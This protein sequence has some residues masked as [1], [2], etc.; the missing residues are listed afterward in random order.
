MSD[1]EGA[2]QERV[3]IGISFGNSYSSIAYTSSDGKAEVIANEEGDRQIPS[4]LSYIDGEEFQGTQAKSQLVRNPQ[5]TVAYFRDF[6]GQEFK[7]ID[8]TACHQS[9]HPIQHGSTVAFSIHD[10]LRPASPGSASAN[11]IV[12]VSEIATR[13]L[14]RLKNSASDFLGKPVN[15][16][17]IAVPT[18]FSD[19]QRAALREA[20]ER[21][22]LE[23][24]QLVHEPVAALLAYDARPSQPSPDKK[25]AGGVSQTADKI[26]VVVDVGGTRSDVAVLA[27]C[28]GMYTVLATAHDYDVAGA[29]FDGA[30]MDHVAKEFLKK[31][32]GAPDPRAEPRAAAK[33]RLEAEAVK[34]ALS[35]GASA[36]FSLES[37]VAGIDFAMPLNRSRYELLVARHVAALVR[38]A[39]HAVDK[40]GLDAGL[41]VA[42]V[43]CAG[44]SAHTPRLARALEAAFPRAAAAGAVRAPATDPAALNPSELAARGCAVQASL[45]EGFERADIEE[46]TEAVVTVTPHLSRALGVV[47]VAGPAEEEVLVPI[48]EPDTP[49]PVRRT[50]VVPAPAQDG[51]V[52]VRL[53][54]GE[55]G[56][57]VT[58]PERKRAE[59]NGEEAGGSEGGSEEDSEE[60][61]EDED[62]EEEE[63]RERVWKATRTVAEVGLKGV[64]KG[65][66]VEVQVNVGVGLEV[67]VMVREVGGKGGVRGVVGGPEGV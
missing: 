15:A 51:D 66:M 28:G 5:N 36:S 33:L 23:V 14:R 3:A 41:D 16:A 58:R 59:T 13:H 25:K 30:L 35:L 18:N 52:L 62:E 22:G 1:D 46:S 27:S 48:V 64:R 6:L 44:G 43:V 56:V 57:K 53:C 7:S 2:A 61:D 24:L 63:V 26:V 60:D 11:A 21:A 4:I 20:A 45:I 67:Q 65:R 39:A 10:T 38:A 29:T 8:P 47:V 40:A 12:P 50:A 54:E 19:A 55:R 32:K 49:V 42:E 9:A 31:H 37:L 17:V 34:K